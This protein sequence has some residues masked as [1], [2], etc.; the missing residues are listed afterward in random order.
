VL[1]YDLAPDCGVDYSNGSAIR[2]I[3]PGIRTKRMGVEV[4]TEQVRVLTAGAAR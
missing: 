4:M 2:V 3:D 1:C